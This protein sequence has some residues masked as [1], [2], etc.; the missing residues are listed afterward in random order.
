MLR[1]EDA[2]K[3]LEQ[4]RTEHWQ[5]VC[6]EAIAA[7]PKT[8]RPA[9]Y[10][11]L[12]RDEQ[13]APLAYG[14]QK[15]YQEAE[16]AQAEGYARLGALVPDERL[17]ILSAFFPVAAPA[18]EATWQLMARLPY[19]SGWRRKAFRLR[20]AGGTTGTTPAQRAWLGGLVNALG[21]YRDKDVA[22]LA[23]W[24]PYLGHGYAAQPLGVLFATAIDAGGAGGEA[25]FDTLLASARGDHPIGAMGRHVTT[26]LLVAS[27]PDGWE[28]VE[29]MLLAAQREEGLRQ[30]ILETVDEAQPRAFRRMLRLILD[31]DLV[32]FSATVRAADVWFG[33]NWDV[34][35]AR[36]VRDALAAAL[37]LL[38]DPAARREALAAPEPPAAYLA[39]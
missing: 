37:R 7:L 12:R 10:A 16:R 29:K 23:G 6:L 2:A 11:I 33:F 20:D 4:E 18:V 5:K 19:Q 22:W 28:F 30:V 14:S 38:E 17:A 27:R 34:D 25:V 32:R 1:R 35:H 31:H 21:E 39:L 26:G 15:A 8:L 13:G 36:A 24:A 3:L 9:A